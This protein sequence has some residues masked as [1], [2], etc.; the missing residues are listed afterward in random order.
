MKKIRNAAVDLL[1]HY[2]SN[3]PM[4]KLRDICKLAQ[5]LDRGK[6][7]TNEID[8]LREILSDPQGVWYRFTENLFAE[9]NP[10]CLRKFVECFLLNASLEGDGV[11]R[12]NEQKYD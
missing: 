9:V 2:L 4:K 5:R 11:A 1:L 6:I 3:N 10:W 8:G 7:H 12:E